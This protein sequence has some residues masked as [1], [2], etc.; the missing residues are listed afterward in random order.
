M[1]QVNSCYCTNYGFD[2]LESFI[3]KPEVEVVDL[4]FVGDNYDDNHG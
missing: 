3:L 2:L 4:Y 1:V